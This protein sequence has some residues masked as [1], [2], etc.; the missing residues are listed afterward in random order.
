MLP[1]A[2]GVQRPDGKHDVSMGVVTVGVMDGDVG[3]HAIRYE[4][5]LYEIG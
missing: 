1:G 4:F 5:L 3:A 2:V